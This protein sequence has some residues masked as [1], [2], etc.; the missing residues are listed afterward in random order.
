MN[1]P[2]ADEISPRSTFISKD[3][4]RGPKFFSHPEETLVGDNDIPMSY[5]DE[6]LTFSEKD[7]QPMSENIYTEPRSARKSISFKTHD[8]SK[9]ENDSKSHYSNKSEFESPENMRKSV[10]L[11]RL[12]DVIRSMHG[13]K[14][15]T[16]F[17]L[18]VSFDNNITRR[19][20]S[21]RYNVPKKI[22]EKKKG[23]IQ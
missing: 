7:T 8:D 12:K 21:T 9:S 18:D 3:A 19:R 11:E 2:G 1:S 4:E 13:L 20:V 17:D 23:V 6:E 22:T 16:S 10:V 5:V 15:D 14:L